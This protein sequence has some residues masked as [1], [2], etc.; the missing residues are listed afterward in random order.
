VDSPIESAE[1]LEELVAQK[2]LQIPHL[3]LHTLLAVNFKGDTT[4][5]KRGRN[6]NCS[7]L[8]IGSNSIKYLT[9]EYK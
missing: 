5:A 2:L 3:K 8:Q 1:A 7:N 9:I 6:E 4:Q